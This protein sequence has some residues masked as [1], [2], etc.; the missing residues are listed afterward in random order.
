MKRFA[1]LAFLSLSALLPV[2]APAFGACASDSG[3]VIYYG[4]GMF[5]SPARARVQALLMDQ[6]IRPAL[7]AGAKVTFSYAYNPSE[8]DIN[9]ALQAAAQAASGTTVK[10]PSWLKVP[11]SAPTSFTNAVKNLEQSANP[12]TYVKDGDLTAHVAL[13]SAK[14]GAGKRVIVVAHSQGN[15]YANKAYD[16]LSSKTGFAIV[17]VG[18]PASFTA[19]NGPYTTLTND[20]IIEPVPNRRAP[21][22]T[23]GSAFVKA[24]KG[25][26]GHSFTSQYL[27]GDVSGPKIVAQV[28]STLASLTCPL[29]KSAP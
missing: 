22:T 1:P 7:P 28:T 5:I 11:S 10:V 21:N 20:Q 25:S 18:T 3:V 14:L 26:D 24:T 8:D 23:N 13:Y 29:G 2:A 15:F 12:D 19:G 6:K 16:R 17:S 27:D 9:Q 4:N